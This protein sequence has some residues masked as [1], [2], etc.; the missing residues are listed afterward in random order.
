MREINGRGILSL[1]AQSLE[2]IMLVQKSKD[3]RRV[4][5]SVDAREGENK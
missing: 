3:C 5:D 2:I 4:I 1:F